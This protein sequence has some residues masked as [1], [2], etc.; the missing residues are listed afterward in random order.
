[1]VSI[2]LAKAFT[3]HR[4]E[5]RNEIGTFHQYASH[6]RNRQ[7]VLINDDR[8]NPKLVMI[9]PEKCQLNFFS[10]IL[11]KKYTS[12]FYFTLPLQLHQR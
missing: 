5:R 9:V 6:L 2:I 8:N 4:K 10:S 7:N 11:P 1:M 3:V 12:F